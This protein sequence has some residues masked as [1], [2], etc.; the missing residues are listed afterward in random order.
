MVTAI[1]FALGIHHT[2]EGL[3]NMKLGGRVSLITG[4]GR[5]IG[6]A[7]AILFAKEGADIV[8]ND[9]DLSSAEETAEK[10]KK[11]GR[12]AIAIKADITKPDDVDMMVENALKDLGGIHILVNNAGIPP[13]FIPT[14]ESPIEHWDKVVKT[15]LYGTYL[16]SR[17]VGQWMV[18]QKTG[19]ILNIGSI[20]GVGGWPA[21]TDYGSAK[22]GIMYTTRALAAEWAKYNINV[23][24]VA[25]GYVKTHLMEKLIKEG[26]VNEEAVKERTPLGRLAKVDDIAKA[27]LFL[28]SD[29]ASYITG[30]TLPVDGGWL[31]FG[32]YS[33]RVN[34]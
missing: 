25:P 27:G 30:V 2:N 7:I 31:A 23:N 33:S 1:G 6:Q 4:A 17:R 13:K 10:V 26:K 19:K 32:G 24:C 14:I 5:G 15:H 18:A 9:I 11:I 8:V 21:R 20:V 29:D 22:A 16:C 3:V 12:K 28:V 34:C